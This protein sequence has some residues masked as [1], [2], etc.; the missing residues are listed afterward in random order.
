MRGPKKHLFKGWSSFRAAEHATSL[1]AYPN[2][3]RL[4]PIA[5]PYSDG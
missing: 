4:P 5:E 3:H 1:V 2:I